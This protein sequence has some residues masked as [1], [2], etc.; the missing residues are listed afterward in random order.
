MLPMTIGVAKGSILGPVFFHFYINGFSNISED[1]KF[2][3]FA[4]DTTVTLKDENFNSLII[5]VSNIKEKINV[6]AVANRL[7]KN[8]D[9]TKSLVFSF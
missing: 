2:T 9:K 1:I 7:T 8:F 5:N 6:W 4:D 3:V